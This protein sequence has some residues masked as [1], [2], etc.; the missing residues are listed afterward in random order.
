[1]ARENQLEVEIG[2]EDVGAWAAREKVSIEVAARQARLAFFQSCASR[3]ATDRLFLAHHAGDQVETIL[4]HLLRGTGLRGLSGMR[5]VARISGLRVIRPFLETPR[6]E[7]PLPPRFYDDES[8]AGDD[9]L[10]NRLRR[11]AIPMLR[12][13]FGRDFEP[14]LRRMATV[15]RE[16]DRF[17]ASLTREALTASLDER[18]ELRMVTLRG[19]PLALR[20]RVIRRWL[21]DSAV[22]GTGF[23]EVQTVLALDA[24]PRSPAK[25]N[26]PGGWHVRRRAGKIFLEPPV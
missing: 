23:R 2:E 4:I 20:R 21:E 3:W 17:L 19:L 16:E 15:L 26:L 13:L 22:P 8:N 14:G 12:E 9:F 18:N 7:I 25:A 6:A 10:R 11:H 24:G 1:L 5:P